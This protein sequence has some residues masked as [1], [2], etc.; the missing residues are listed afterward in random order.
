MAVSPS[1]VR[2][3][4]L[5]AIVLILGLSPLGFLPVSG[6]GGAITLL[7]IPVILAG[8]LEG[9]AAAALLG[10]LFGLIAGYKFPVPHL[11]FHIL[12]RVL[13]GLAAG[14]TFQ[15]LR[16]SSADGSQVTIASAGAALAG[17]FTNTA[18]MSFV[19]LLTGMVAPES[20]LTIVLLHGTLELVAAVL[21]V[22]PS[23]IALRET[24]Q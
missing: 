2:I 6:A 12:V 5:M 19:A 11:F 4:C 22:V 18:G 24:I 20:L 8:T 10:A 9:P 7:H 17:T 1:N 3:L 14:L 21:V 23:T 16:S 13:A 15:T